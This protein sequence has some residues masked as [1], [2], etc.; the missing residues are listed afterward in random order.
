MAA[1][2]VKA[3]YRSETRKF[4]FS[5]PVFPS[6]EQLYSQASTNGSLR[7]PVMTYRSPVAVSG[8]PSIP[9]FLSIEASVLP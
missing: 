1:F 8:F 3:T 2:T 6:Y 4:S 9:F 5:D 7:I